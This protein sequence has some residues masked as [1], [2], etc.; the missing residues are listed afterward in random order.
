MAILFFIIIYHISKT[1]INTYNSIPSQLHQLRIIRYVITSYQ[2]TLI[3]KVV[4]SKNLHFFQ[5]GRCRSVPDINANTSL[6]DLTFISGTESCL[7]LAFHGKQIF[8]KPQS[9]R[10][11]FPSDRSFY[12]DLNILYRANS[13]RRLPCFFSFF[14]YNFYILF[15]INWNKNLT[16]EYKGLFS[17]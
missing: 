2:Q 16:S 7:I 5:V 4:V 9:L 12:Q 17:R 14:P 3:F 1:F 15:R 13:S 10:R 6:Y 11:C 8:T